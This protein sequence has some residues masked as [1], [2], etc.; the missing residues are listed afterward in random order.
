MFQG[1]WWRLVLVLACAIG[2]SVPC[3][4]AQSDDPDAE[5]PPAPA[6]AT[7]PD[8]SPALNEVT[9]VVQS[10]GAANH[11]RPGEWVGVEVQA[12]DSSDKVR[13]VLV[14]M[15]IEDADGDTTWMQRTIVTNPGARQSLWLYARMPFSAS[16]GTV[17]ALSAH[18]AVEDAS[19]PGGYRAGRVLGSTNYPVGRQAVT[20][21]TGLIGVVGV[22]PAGL[23]QYPWVGGSQ[24]DYAIT[25]HE[26]TLIPGGLSPASMP[27]RWMGLMA[28]EALVWTG[29]SASDQP[30]QLREAQAEAIRE[31]VRRGGHLIVVLPAVGQ[32]WLGAPANPLADIMPQVRVK[33]V[34]NVN[35]AAYRQLLTRDRRV[36]LPADAVVQ[37][38]IPD[39]NAGP[40]DAMPLMTGPDGDIVA[41]R[42]QVGAGAVTVVGLD[43]TNRR[44]ADVQRALQADQFWNRILG[45]RLPLFTPDELRRMREPTK[46]NVLPEY[47][48]AVHPAQFDEFIGPA[49]ALSGDAAAGVLLAF[50]VFL[51]YW[52][53]AGPLGFFLL[54]QRNLKQHSWLVFLGVTAVFTA[55]AW[56]GATILKKRRIEGK[57]VTFVDA[58][59]GQT[60]QRA[61][62]WANMLLPG[63]GQTLVSI[64]PGPNAG[65]DWHNALTAW[66]QPYNQGG[67]SGWSSFPDA[68]GYPVDTRSPDTLSVPTRSTAKQFQ[69]DWAGGLPA[70]WG[71]IHPIADS[72]VPIG[73]EVRLV[74]RTPE[75][76]GERNWELRGAIT[77]NLPRPLTNVA[78][79]LVRGPRSARVD[80]PE[81][82]FDALITMRPPK[83]AWEPGATL[84]LDAQFDLKT[85]AQEQ[86]GAKLVQ[87]RGT[88]ATYSSAAGLGS[89]PS[90]QNQKLGLALFSM[91]APPDP[92]GN[93]R[94][95]ARREVAH[96]WDLA[97]WFTQPCLIVIGEVEA[98]ECPVPIAMGGLTAE[99]SRKRLKGSTIVRWVFPLAPVPLRAQAAGPEA[100][101]PAP[102]GAGGESGGGGGGGGGSGEG[103]G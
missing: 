73:Q 20:S 43:L 8:S 89:P 13:S 14:R 46:I 61:R 94:V 25:G 53:L 63:Y 82:Q 95:L 102:E 100:P 52:L 91:L 51:A 88:P 11:M 57:H 62:T 48:A 72:D 90:E 18:E 38:F 93:T 37:S 36:S 80:P 69:V 5:S 28:M 15:A 26:L 16:T 49:I 27:D 84:V 21:F 78:F 45:K 83:E 19:E 71:M 40:F 10:L 29:S 85:S 81:P 97:R 76:P 86:A 96:G 47:N 64:A 2:T 34:E 68:R 24:N 92:I 87:L 67:G 75:K 33:R 74:P 70:D 32:A 55:V 31:Y 60:N 59:Y 12:S 4:F 23:E 66:E 35:L 79:V 30:G 17:I 58:V 98:G 99:E 65:V 101:E 39:V 41:I 7:F 56:T 6:P 42:R 1:R 3:T 22:R 77:H 44:V 54:K 9:L 50:V 103:N